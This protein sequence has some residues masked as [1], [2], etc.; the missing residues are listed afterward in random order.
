[1]LFF[2]CIIFRSLFPDVLVLSG[3]SLNREEVAAE[4]FDDCV[5]HSILAGTFLLS[6]AFLAHLLAQSAE[7]DRR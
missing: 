4:K 6:G 1:M 3:I 7:A 5:V 2:F